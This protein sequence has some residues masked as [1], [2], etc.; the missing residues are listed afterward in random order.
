M[1]NLNPNKAHGHNVRNIWMLK[2]CD[3]S[4]CKP[5]GIIFQPCLE[6]GKLFSEWY[7]ANVVSVFKKGNKQ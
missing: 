1:R 4:I 2:I 3:E 6:N 7:K 5:L